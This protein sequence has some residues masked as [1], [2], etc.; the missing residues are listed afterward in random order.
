MAGQLNPQS[1]RV[2]LSKTGSN[3]GAGNRKLG[4]E[5]HCCQAGKPDLL[6][7]IQMLTICHFAVNR[8]ILEIGARRQPTFLATQRVASCT[9]SV[10]AFRR[11]FTEP[12]IPS[13]VE[14]QRN[15]RVPVVRPGRKAGAGNCRSCPELHESGFVFQV[16]T[17][18]EGL[19]RRFLQIALPV[20][21]ICLLAS[22]AAFAQGQRGRG[23]GGFPGFG[24]GGGA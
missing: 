10:S 4:S 9:G 24:G 21:A 7:T 1:S 18:R 22:D 13:W 2:C 5:P 15:H 12:L 23:R 6:C 19:M 20:L 3:R 8:Q 11:H 17:E 16:T 14:L